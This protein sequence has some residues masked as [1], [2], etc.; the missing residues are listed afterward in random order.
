LV[1]GGSAYAHIAYPR[2]LTLKSD[3]VRDAFQRV[4]RMALAAAV[5]VVG[6]R[7]DG[8]RMRARLHYRAGH[9]G[10]FREG[11]H[12]LCDAASTRQLTPST[13]DAI[14][15][16]EAALSHA[17]RAAV[18]EVEIAENCAGSERACHFELAA[19]GDPSTLAALT[20]VDGLRGA[21]CS[22][23]HQAR[24]LTLWGTPV[25]TETVA[26]ARLTRHARAF[27]QGN[28]Y[29][30]HDLVTRVVSAAPAGQSLD[31]YA[32]VGLFAAALA[33]RG[34]TNVVAVEGDAVSA[35]DLKRNAAAF[36]RAI[37]A[38]HQAVEV[39]LASRPP[40]GADAVI[41]DPPRTGMTRDAVQGVLR[42][43]AGRVL[44]LSCD[45]AT[46]ARDA[47]LLVDRGYTLT[48]VEAF[49]MFPNTAHIETL[50]IFDSV[51]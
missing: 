19:G 15:R 35:D 43:G 20:E 3:V 24:A 7:P 16:L 36:G 38:R 51:K 11:S 9:L 32:G 22:A 12:E 49:D 42:L 30:L 33:A 5:P 39:F 26:G 21:S 6:S 27:F 13:I 47:R 34:D 23:E 28:R 4:A 37:A 14:A 50:A 2:Q 31:L 45:V 41:V 29:L 40:R 48:S 18:R 1:C 8:Y 10:F 25:V 46:L 17:P 44:Y